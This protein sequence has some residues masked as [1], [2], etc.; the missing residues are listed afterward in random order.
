ML[1][2]RPVATQLHKSLSQAGQQLQEL[3]VLLA[4][5]CEQ[6]DD[7]DLGPDQSAINNNAQEWHNDLMQVLLGAPLAAD[8]ALAGD[9]NALF[10]SLARDDSSSLGLIGRLLMFRAARTEQRPP[11][12]KEIGEAYY[13][14]S[15]DPNHE[16]T[17]LRDALVRWLV[18]S[19]AA[20][21]LG[22]RI[23]LAIVGDRFDRTRHASDAI[24]VELVEVRGWVVLRE[25]GSVY[26]RASVVVK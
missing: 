12:L 1:T 14:W 24:G 2:P 4:T 7:Q 6:L 11:L 26:T 16:S 18:D 8:P 21:G 5:A 3:S 25:N 13:Q 9:R 20:V 15:N 10:A 22:H 17:A 19:C 23:E